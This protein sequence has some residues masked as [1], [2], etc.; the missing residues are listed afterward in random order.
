MMTKMLVAGVIGA[1]ACGCCTM[2]RDA[3]GFVAFDGTMAQEAPG[4][5][6][7]LRFER[8][9]G[10]YEKGWQKG[11]TKWLFTEVRQ[12]KGLRWDPAAE[13]FTGAYAD[14]ANRFL[15]KEYHNGWE[16]GA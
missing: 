5:Y 6:F 1:V 7:I 16:L 10:V 13:R 3:E 14:E 9:D 12:L 4:E 11:L 8:P 15:E 2:N